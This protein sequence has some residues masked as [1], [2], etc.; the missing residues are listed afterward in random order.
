MRTTPP[1]ITIAESGDTRFFVC[2]RKYYIESGRY[3]E[4]VLKPIP[5][6]YAKDKIK[7]WRDLNWTKSQISMWLKSNEQTLL[8][9]PKSTRKSKKQVKFA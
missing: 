1:V 9:L 3:K 8:N 2:G 4:Y 7:L 6:D 5:Y